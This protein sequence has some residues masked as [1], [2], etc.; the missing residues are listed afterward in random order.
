MRILQFFVLASLVVACNSNSTPESSEK[1]KSEQSMDNNAQA[2]SSIE[3][4]KWVLVE[5]D[6][7]RFK[8]S[9]QDSV[10][11]MLDSGQKRITGRLGCNTFFGKYT[12]EVK[13]KISFSDL[14][15]TAM[16]CPDLTTEKSILSLLQKADNYSVED[17]V[18]YLK[19]ARVKK[20]AGFKM[21]K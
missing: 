8:V 9:S 5:L 3:D 4:K 7:N 13:Q 17:G 1:P 2:N 19:W 12:M 16:A 21:V 15:N 20:L 6:G 18:L 10:Y 14:E 11:F